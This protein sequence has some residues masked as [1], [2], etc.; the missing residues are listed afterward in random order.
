MQ[1]QQVFDWQKLHTV[2]YRQIKTY[3]EKRPKAEHSYCHSHGRNMRSESWKTIQ[4]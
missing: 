2:Q 4:K 3:I 1:T